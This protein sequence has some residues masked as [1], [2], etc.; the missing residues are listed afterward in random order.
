MLS[1]A[2]LEVLIAEAYAVHCIVTNLGIEPGEVFVS[3]ALAANVSPPAPCAAVMIKRGEKSCGI[4]VS[5]LSDRG[6]CKQFDEAWRRFA[7]QRKRE[8][9]RVELDRMVQGTYVWRDRAT[10]LF[11]LVSKGFELRPGHMVN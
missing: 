1:D 8:L 11:A 5:M 2:Q 10:I 7:N 4:S 9:S 6:E 3:S